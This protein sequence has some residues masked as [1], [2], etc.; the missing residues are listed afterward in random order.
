MLLFATLDFASLDGPSS[1]EIPL[2]RQSVVISFV[3]SL[4]SY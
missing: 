2:S 3:S 1:V 4:V